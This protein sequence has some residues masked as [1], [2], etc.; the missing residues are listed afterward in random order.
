M[1]YDERGDD[2]KLTTFEVIRTIFSPYYY[3]LIQLYEI[4]Y[5]E[6]FKSLN[7]VAFVKNKII[8]WLNDLWFERDGVTACTASASMDGILAL[9]SN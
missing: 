6:N 1:G 7:V 5:N 3:T 9:F 2:K 4:G 8:Q